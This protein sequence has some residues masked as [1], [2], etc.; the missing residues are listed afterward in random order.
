MRPI[1]LSVSN[2]VPSSALF[3]AYV[4]TSPPYAWNCCS[5]GTLNPS[6]QKRISVYSSSDLN[7][8]LNLFMMLLAVSITPLDTPSSCVPSLATSWGSRPAQRAGKSCLEMRVTASASWLCTS[9]GA[10]HI[11]STTC[12]LMRSLS[13]W[14]MQSAG[15]SSLTHL[16]LTMFLKSTEADWR[17]AT[18]WG[19]LL[20]TSLLIRVRMRR[21]KPGCTSFDFRYASD[22]FLSAL[23]LDRMF[24]RR[25][26][27]APSDW[28]VTSMI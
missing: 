25:S 2:T 4:P 20:P 16:F 18:S 12:V 23:S 1:S 5:S 9:C 8:Y 3:C 11:S 19:V 22:C 26:R 14:E 28:S 13:V 15:S 6:M 21:G 27:R 17:M 10:T 24:A 7:T